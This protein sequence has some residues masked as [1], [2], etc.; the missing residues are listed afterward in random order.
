MKNILIKKQSICRKCILESIPEEIVRVCGHFQELFET[1]HLPYPGITSMPSAQG[2]TTTQ[3]C[4]QQRRQMMDSKIV[5]YDRTLKEQWQPCLR[6]WSQ[7]GTTPNMN[8]RGTQSPSCH[9]VKI[10]KPEYFTFYTRFATYTPEG[11]N[12][13]LTICAQSYCVSAK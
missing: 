1:M 9:Q 3:L 13:G 12:L 6:L 8:M 5:S 11:Q 7:K 4:L 2:S 10:N